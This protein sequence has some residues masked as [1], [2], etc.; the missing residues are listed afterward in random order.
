MFD[1]T[2]FNPGNEKYE[3]KFKP[4]LYWIKSLD[5]GD[6][7]LLDVD[8]NDSTL[9]FNS[10]EGFIGHDGG[11]I[12]NLKSSGNNA[13]FIGIFDYSSGFLSKVNYTG[14]GKHRQN[15]AHNLKSDPEFVL[16]KPNS[17]SG[18][19]IAW[20][21]SFGFRGYLKFNTDDKFIDDRMIFDKNVQNKRTLT[22]AGNL[23]TKNETYSAYMFGNSKFFTSGFYEGQKNLQITTRIKPELLIVKRVDNIGGWRM[24][25]NKLNPG[26]SLRVNSFGKITKNDDLLRVE[27]LE[28]GFSI[29]Q[30][31]SAINQTNAKYI[32]LA[33][34]S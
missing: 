17:F 5:E 1:H 8:K 33:F 28:N 11:N 27:F 10:D 19:W 29:K 20:H 12:V 18:D 13:H 22:V 26:D 24:F 30:E 15:L 34:S 4:G 7:Y 21:Y 2:I 6:H 14:D 32:Y 31:C 25:S 3:A 16:F 9:S 23:N